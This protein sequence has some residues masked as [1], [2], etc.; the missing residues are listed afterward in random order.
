[1]EESALH[2]HKLLGPPPP[3]P[4]T[5]PCVVGVGQDLEENKFRMAASQADTQV[6]RGLGKVGRG[7]QLA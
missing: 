3:L 6:V 2:K 4:T 5:P 7:C 1:M